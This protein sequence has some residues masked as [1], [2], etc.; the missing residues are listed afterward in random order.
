MG[1]KPAAATSAV[2]N[3]SIMI[4]HRW[5]RNDH[6]FIGKGVARVRMKGG[7]NGRNGVV[8]VAMLVLVVLLVAVNNKADVL[9]EVHCVG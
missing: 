8:G 7:G 5:V 6:L 1:K 2:T 4:I 3:G 9:R